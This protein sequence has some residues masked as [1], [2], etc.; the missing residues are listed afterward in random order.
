MSFQSNTEQAASGLRS[1]TIEPA[2]TPLAMQVAAQQ[3]IMRHP[4]FDGSATSAFGFA[5]AAVAAILAMSE[6]P[7]VVLYAQSLERRISQ[8]EADLNEC[9]EFLEG[10]SD[11]I[12]GDYGEPSPNRAMQLM[13]MI[14]ETL[15]GRP[16]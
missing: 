7:A 14:D 5:G 6:H 9:V 15:H 13:N 12:D 2:S 16:Y 11:V 3:A 8:L 1:P 10:Q 4:F